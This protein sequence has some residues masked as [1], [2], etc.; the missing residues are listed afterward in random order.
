M[1]TSR[2]IC[3]GAFRSGTV[4]A[5]ARRSFDPSVTR[6]I[7]LPLLHTRRYAAAACGSRS[8]T[9]RLICCDT[10][11]PRTFSANARLSLDS[12]VTRHILLPLLYTRRC[13]ATACGSR[14]STC[15]SRSTRWILFGLG[16]YLRTRCCRLTLPSLDSNCY[17]YSIRNGT[18]PLQVDL[19]RVLSFGQLRRGLP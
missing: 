9:S 8:S 19:A 17:C 13:A 6:H 1:S 3:R 12:S 18:L 4:S 16:Q 2:L 10:A 15:M 14:S 5:D 7:L 11:G